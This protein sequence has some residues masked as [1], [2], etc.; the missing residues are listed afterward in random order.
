MTEGIHAPRREPAVPDAPASLPDIGDELLEQARTLDAGRSARTLTPGA[1]AALKQTLLALVGGTRLEEHDSPG[2]ASLF[3]LSGD[4]RLGTSDGGV[5]LT[6]GQWAAIPDTP[7]DLAATT[8]AV[9]LLTVAVE[10]G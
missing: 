2:P 6:D 5:A 4:V 8:D 1:G 9:V 3:V 7:H 10:P